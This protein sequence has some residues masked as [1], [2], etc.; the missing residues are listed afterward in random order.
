M[1]WSDQA[2]VPVAGEGQPGQ[3]DGDGKGSNE[4]PSSPLPN[5]AERDLAASPTPADLSGDRNEVR[6]HGVGSASYVCRLPRQI[7]LALC[8]VAPQ[9][10]KT[11]V[12]VPDN[13]APTA[14]VTA[15]AATT[16]AT[17]Q[18]TPSRL[19][20]QSLEASGIPHHKHLM[21]P[22]AKTNHP[23][24]P[25][26]CR[27]ATCRSA[28]ARRPCASRCPRPSAGLR[29]ET[30]A[31]PCRVPWCRGQPRAPPSLRP[32]LPWHPS[33]PSAGK[34]ASLA[35]HRSAVAVQCR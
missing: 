31:C 22:H 29:R 23:S 3:Q 35:I 18:A 20:D 2:H 7:P 26:S 1:S 32:S 9:E 4:V 17:T 15:T 5:G 12:K 14:Q 21:S 11:D 8:T 34:K 24:Q 6:P 33:T 27:P 28:S 16:Q 13:A 30:C 10:P 25:R 19:E